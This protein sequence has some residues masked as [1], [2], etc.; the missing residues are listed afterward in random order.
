MKHSHHEVADVITRFKNEFFAQHSVNSYQ[1]RTLYALEKCRTAALGG[2][3]TVCDSCNTK[4][5]AY[6]S[7]R[8][9]HCPKCQGSKQLF[10]VEDL[11][12][13]T[14]DVTHFHIVFT[15]PH[16]LN[17]ICLCNT[18]WFFNTM[19]HCVWDTLKTFG[20]SDFACETAAVCMLHTWGQNL[21][22]HPHIHCIVPAIGKRF[23]GSYKHIGKTYSYL[24]NVNKLSSVF[25]GKM[26]QKIVLF[27]EN[28]NLLYSFKNVVNEAYS[29]DWVVHA[30]PA[31]GKAE[32]VIAY[33]GNYTQRVA[34]SNN[35]IVSIDNQ[36][37][38][39]RYKDYADNEKTKTMK[40]SGVEFLRRFCMHILP[41]GFVK[42]RRYGLYSSRI[43]TLEKKQIDK[44]IVPEHPK[45]TTRERLI[46]LTGFDVCL[47][48]FCKKGTLVPFHE[49]PRIRSPD[50]QFIA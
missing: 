5:Q 45:E 16:I 19:F 9:R 27:L 20:Y 39:F 43:R 12:N 8:N 30:K 24:Y 36:Y 23:S 48:P 18:K 33:L 21:S 28:N 26:M 49:R 31:F 7:C 42:I 2:Y 35:R 13:T 1:M 40:L 25:R 22:F 14:F 4:V 6:N 38:V 41:K 10:W 29:K 15:I 11:V 32:H 37:V 50:N 3:V 44:M 46:R 47:C 34:I 17:E